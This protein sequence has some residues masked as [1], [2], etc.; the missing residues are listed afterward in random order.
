[1]SKIRVKIL[2]M[3][4]FLNYLYE[5]LIKLSC[6]EFQFRIQFKSEEK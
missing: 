1:M 4:I 5:I 2:L 6:L 3:V